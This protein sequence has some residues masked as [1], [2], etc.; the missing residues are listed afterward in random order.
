MMVATPA[1]PYGG[2]MTDAGDSQLDVTRV[3]RLVRLLR[4]FKLAKLVRMFKLAKYL[5]DAE[6]LL[7]PGQLSVIKLVMLALL[8]CHWFGCL[9]W[10]VSDLELSIDDIGSPWYAGHNNWHPPVWLRAEQDLGT[11][12]LHAFFWGAGMVTSMVPYDIEPVTKVEAVVTTFTMFFGL[13]LN[14]YVISS[15]TSAIASMN[16]KKEL[17]GKQLDTIKSYLVLK[18]VPTDLKARILEYFQYVFTSS[19]A[20]ADVHIL[21]RM[22]V[23]LATQLA[24]STNR[25]IAGRCA[26]FRDISNASLVSIISE[27]HPVVYVPGQRILADGLPLTT[28][29]FINK[30][31]V[32]YSDGDKKLGTLC[33]NDNFGLTYYFEVGPSPPQPPLAS[34][35]H[36]P[37]PSSTLPSHP[38]LASLL[39]LA[40]LRHRPARARALLLRGRHLL[41]PDGA[42]CRE[43][44]GRHAR[45]PAL[46]RAHRGRQGE[47]EGARQGPRRPTVQLH[48]GAQ[49]GRYQPPRE[50]RRRLQLPR[51]RWRRGRTR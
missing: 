47:V 14:A 22:P 49:K 10:L 4:L 26:F 9:W 25:K 24:L 51:R 17:A 16:S 38:P 6:D 21:D 43:A 1:N 31:L 23:Q 39:P 33:D 3:N 5:E 40:E 44:R 15:M 35:Q 42:R 8:C 32:A 28:V 27:L 12:Y 36:P 2:S 50:P 7:N 13:M 45:R 30:G 46:P 48:R 37:A 18:H 11:K 20:L 41:R 29:Y 34:L 19:Q